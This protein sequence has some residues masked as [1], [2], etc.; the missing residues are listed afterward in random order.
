MTLNFLY[1]YFNNFLIDKAAYNKYLRK[2]HYLIL[3]L[4][5]LKI[6]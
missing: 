3:S 1:L 2:S 5:L 4:N 6:I